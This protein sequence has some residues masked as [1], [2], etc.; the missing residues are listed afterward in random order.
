MKTFTNIFNA[1]LQLKL[2]L[3]IRKKEKEKKEEKIRYMRDYSV[4]TKR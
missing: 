1:K 3:S 2:S 4:H